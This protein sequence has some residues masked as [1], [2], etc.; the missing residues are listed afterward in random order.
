MHRPARGPQ[1][2]ARLEL[3]AERVHQLG[4]RAAGPLIGPIKGRYDKVRETT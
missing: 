2:G 3:D 1:V 4:H